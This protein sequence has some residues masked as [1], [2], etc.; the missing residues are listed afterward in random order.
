MIAHPSE[1]VLVQ[2]LL[3][4]TPNEKVEEIYCDLEDLVFVNLH[5]QQQ[6]FE[7]QL[8]HLDALFVASDCPRDPVVL[9]LEELRV[10]VGNSSGQCLEN[11]L[12]LLPH[13]LQEHLDLPVFARQGNQLV[14]LLCDSLQHEE[15]LVPL[16]LVI[17]VDGKG[18]DLN[19]TN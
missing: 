5:H 13:T 14:E 8:T 12:I 16:L 3:K 7:T 4:V 15:V 11:I 10:E 9:T 6:V 19:Q 17:G 2:I 1:R 18:C